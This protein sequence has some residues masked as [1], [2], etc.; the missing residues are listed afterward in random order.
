MAVDER[1][2]ALAGR[3]S[4]R[5][6]LVGVSRRR[7]ACQDLAALKSPQAV[8][9]LVSALADADQ[10]VRQTAEQALGQMGDPLALDAM[11]LGYALTG[12]EALLAILSGKGRAAPEKA[13]LATEDPTPAQEAW[14]LQ[15]PKD[16]SVLALVP[17]GDFLAGEAGFPVHLPPYWLGLAAVSNAQYGRFLNE[18]GPP[19]DRLASYIR[20]DPSGPIA[21]GAD[22]YAVAP[23][24]AELP[25]D[26]VTWAGA[27]AYCKWAALRLPTEL[28]WEKGARGV[29]GRQY[30]WGDEWAEG[31]SRP[32]EGERQPEQPL[33]V[34]AHPTAR[35]PYGCYQMIG[36]PYEWCGDWFEEDAYERYA[37]GDL[38]APG[39]GER[40]VLR[41]GP[42]Q[43][44]TP[45]YL[46]TEY[47]KGTAWRAGTLRC[48]F[49]CARSL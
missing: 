1:V 43:F 28:E 41:G 26:T 22:G 16:G 31:R 18:A 20:L 47:R 30:P 34:R 35:S 37:R 6:P 36:G 15:S 46:R 19:A 8:P 12:S 9:F 4:S 45:V 5:T 17:E 44:G 24:A 3:L 13:E 11:A 10:T 42:W 40:R 49:R 25:V 14:Q 7:R 23:E 39:R 21:R 27:E 33:S 48:G 29:D 2:L 38:R 32:P